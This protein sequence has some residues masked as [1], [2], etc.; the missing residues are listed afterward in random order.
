MAMDVILRVPACGPVDQVADFVAEAEDAGFAGVGIPDT[1]MVTRDA[2]VALALAAQ[3]TS[4]IMLY[5]AVTNPVTR[6]VSVVASLVRTIEELA[7]GRVHVMVGTGFSAVRTIGRRS[8]TLASMRE[9]VARLRQLLSGEEL[10]FDG[11]PSH[12]HYASGVV[13]P[14]I[15]AARGPKALELAGEIGDGVLANVALHPANLEWGRS[16]VSQG[17]A[18]AGRSIDK[19]SD[20]QEIMDI[21]MNIAPSHEEA[22]SQARPVCAHWMTQPA[23]ARLIRIAGVEVPEFDIPPGLMSA[24]PDLY[25]AENQE[26]VTK[27][28]SFL[29]DEMVGR[30]CGVIGAYGTPTEVAERLVQLAEQGVTRILVRTAE[31]YRLPRPTLDAFRDVIF[32]RLRQASATR[33]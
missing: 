5:P 31:T 11:A 22:L 6:H 33:P 17:A 21:S 19:D 16:H 29:S 2:F 27:L 14:I 13:P 10:D 4:R 32:P 23:L 12:L 3:R 20:F 1:Q 30:L 18:L 15:L 26:E 25:H 8:A 28:T 9:A 7:P 24:Y